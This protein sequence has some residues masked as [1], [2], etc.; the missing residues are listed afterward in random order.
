M[1]PGRAARQRL[2]KSENATDSTRPHSWLNGGIESRRAT[3]TSARI[4][5]LTERPMFCTA[6]VKRNA[7]KADRSKTHEACVAFRQAGRRDL[8]FA[9]VGAHQWKTVAQLCV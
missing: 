5:G 2:R 3:R 1:N 7:W 8:L 4:S 6:P 9:R